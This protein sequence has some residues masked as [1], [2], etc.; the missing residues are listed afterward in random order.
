MKAGSISY[1][2]MTRNNANHPCTT[3]HRIMKK[4]GA[5]LG[6]ANLNGHRPAV[7]IKHTFICSSAVTSWHLNKGQIH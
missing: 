1:L 5:L 6:I 7:Y 4:L 3:I 2:F